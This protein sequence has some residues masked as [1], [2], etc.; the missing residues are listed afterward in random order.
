M[1]QGRK[2]LHTKARKIPSLHK[3]YDQKVTIGTVKST[4]K[5][6][7]QHNGV[8]PIKK[9]GPI[10]EEHMAYFIMDDNTSN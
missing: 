8:M 1:G 10:I 5:I 2:L 9:S 3:N 6:P 7:P 4:L